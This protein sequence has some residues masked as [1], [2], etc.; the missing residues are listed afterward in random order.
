M[1]FPKNASMRRDYCYTQFSSL[2][3]IYRQGKGL[4]TFAQAMVA[5]AIAHLVP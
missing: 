2:Q 4:D 1:G 5:V 3:A